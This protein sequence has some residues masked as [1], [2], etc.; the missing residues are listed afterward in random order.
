MEAVVF[1]S[2]HGQHANGDGEV[3]RQ[4]HPTIIVNSEWEILAWLRAPFS[5]G[6]EQALVYLETSVRLVEG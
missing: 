5:S 4:R 2:T 1:Q 3:S 6:D